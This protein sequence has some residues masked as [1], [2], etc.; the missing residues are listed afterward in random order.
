MRA[1]NRLLELLVEPGT[2][3]SEVVRALGEFLELT[4]PRIAIDHRGLLGLSALGLVDPRLPDRW[5]AGRLTS[6]SRT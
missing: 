1:R 5:V 3:R 4:P 2:S 6:A